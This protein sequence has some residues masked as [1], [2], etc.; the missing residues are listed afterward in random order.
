MNLSVSPHLF[1]VVLG[2][3][4]CSWVKVGVKLLCGGSLPPVANFGMEELIILIFVIS[5]IFLVHGKSPFLFLLLWCR[6]ISWFLLG[7]LNIILVVFDEI[8][9]VDLAL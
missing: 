5:N 6:R 7:F 4:S 9:A 3:L 2:L 1:P 8:N